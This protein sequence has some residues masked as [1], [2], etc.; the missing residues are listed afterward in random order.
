[1]PQTPGLGDNGRMERIEDQESQPSGRPVIQGRV[2][3]WIVTTEPD[4]K[5]VDVRRLLIYLEHSLDQGLQWTV[6][7]PNDEPLWSAVRRSVADFL[8]GEWRGGALQGAT[9]EE[10]FFVRCDR[11]TMTQDDIDNGRLVA[12]IG[13]APVRPARV[14]RLPDRPV[15]RARVAGSTTD[16]LR[17]V[18]SPVDSAA[19]G[20]S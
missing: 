16:P 14:R 10:A 17:S 8:L 19:A 1:M 15:D 2:P 5:Y 11:T 7:E 18:S 6:F 9:A 12:V 20:S 3:T 13:V 4:W